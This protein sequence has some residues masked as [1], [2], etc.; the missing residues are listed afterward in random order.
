MPNGQGLFG[1]SSSTQSGIIVPITDDGNIYY[2]FTIDAVE[3]SNHGM[4]YSKVNMELDGGLGDVTAKNELLM[5]D[6]VEKV[7]A[8]G[9]FDGDG[10][11]ILTHK[12]GTNKYYVF[13]LTAFGISGPFI[14]TTGV[15]IP[16]NNID[17]AKGY[18]KVSPT[19]EKLVTAH[20]AYNMIQIANFNIQTGVVSNAFQDDDFGTQRP[21]GVSF[22]PDGR[23]LY[24]STWKSDAPWSLPGGL[25][26]YDLLAG[27]NQQILDSR[28]LISSDV[29]GALQLGSDNRI[30]AARSD[31]NVIGVIRKPNE[32]GTS[33]N[34]VP[35][36]QSL[37]GRTCTRGLPPFVQSFFNQEASFIYDPPCYSVATQFYQNCGFIPD[38]V[39][40]NFGDPASGD[41]NISR[42][43]EPTHLFTS[44]DFFTV[45]LTAYSGLD[46][47]QVSKIINV[48]LIPDLELGNDTAFCDG[49]SYL[50]DPGE[51]YDNYLWHNGYS[52]QTFETDTAGTFWVEVTN[53]GCTNRDSIVLDIS[54]DY[55][56]DSLTS[57]CY[58][59]S[60]QIGGQTVSEPGTYYDSLNTMYGC[61]SIY[62]IEL[63][64]NDTALLEKN[65]SICTGDSVFAGGAWQS[66]SGTYYDYL[67]TYQG[68]DST[69]ITNLTV[70]DIIQTYAQADICEGDSIFL[71][72]D[73]QTTA[74]TYYDTAVSVSGCDSVHTTMLEV[75]ELYS[76][77]IDT[78]ICEGESVY[79]GGEYQ[80]EEGT[81]Y[82]NLQ[83]V[84]GCDSLITT[85]IYVEPLPTVELGNDTLLPIDAEL[86]LEATY[87]GAD[88][89]WQDGSM[90]SV[91]LVT[92]E[93]TYSVTVST[94]C[95][96]VEDAI[97]I[98]YQQPEIPPC[99]PQSPNAFSPNGDG[100][101]DEFKL[102]SECEYTNFN[103]R[104]F[105]RWGKLI[106][107]ATDLDA[108]WDGTS[109][110]KEAPIG[111]YIWR[112]EYSESRDPDLMNALHGSLMLV[113]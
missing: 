69:V 85:N 94:G 56:Y 101:N 97:E 24:I 43:E 28:I 60:I 20:A 13:E 22:S 31:N 25:Y 91:F 21:Y 84:H 111:A 96:S 23:Y 105:D 39:L 92:E 38:S 3:G 51:G 98:T 87:P 32:P 2:I 72:G 89:L 58:G 37:G 11:W 74:G 26:Q 95:G 55:F 88:Y 17:F 66:E 10:T 52:N 108:G 9:N 82:D 112:V 107:E 53:A 49:Y 86:L 83:S 42:L 34:Y 102:I 1:H 45:T 14:H 57:I 106:F 70:D 33:C 77:T 47:A 18:I 30:Y 62:Q 93:G 15:V 6:H 79:A 41:E 76:K 67:D 36:G 73:Y 81:Y 109:N 12:W 68:C 110:G 61:D 59:E 75:F 99:A 4:C 113:K 27:S 5:P 50:I 104:I 48:N 40:W 19:G 54:P 64:V 90:D 63:L 8:V 71:A 80:S 7:T 29:N 44:D 35:S 103:L 16:D 78:N 46:S 100:L 65:I